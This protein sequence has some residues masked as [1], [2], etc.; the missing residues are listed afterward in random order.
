VTI[1]A[2]RR[3][4]VATV[5]RGESILLFVSVVATSAAFG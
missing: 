4:S 1:I 5:P 3:T 2:F